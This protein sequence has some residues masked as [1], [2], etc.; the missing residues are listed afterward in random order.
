MIVLFA[1]LIFHS[2]SLIAVEVILY[3][4]HPICGGISGFSPMWSL[5][6]RIGTH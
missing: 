2:G 6:L 3:F 5:L 1:M 4:V